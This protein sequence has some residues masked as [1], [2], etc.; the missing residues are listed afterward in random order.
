M[1]FRLP[2]RALFVVVSVPFALLA[3]ARVALA[4]A[5][6]PV[7]GGFTLA[8]L[9]DTQIYTWK[10]PETYP[11]QTRWI[12]DNARLY[13]TAYVLH[14]GDITQHNTNHQWQIA[15]DAHALLDRKG[16]PC[17]ITTG[18]HDLGTEGKG[19]TRETPFAK[20]FPVEWFRKQPTFGG[21]YDKE[22]HRTDNNYHLFEAGGRKWLILCLEFGPRDDVLRWGNEVVAKH[23]DRSAIL[24]THA[25][26]RPDNFRFNRNAFIK[27]KDFEVNLGMDRYGLAKGEGGFNDGED[28]W[29]KLVSQHASFV[30]VVS[31]HVC[32]TGRL[33]STGKHGNT[34]HQMVVDYQNQK[35][36]GEGYLRLLQFH[37]DGKKV[38]VADY[39]PLLDKVSSAKNT[40]YEFT[41]APPPAATDKP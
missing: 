20:Y 40:S 36:G 25:Y 23:P 21:F 30:L 27:V 35:D 32:I 33:E 14:V 15:S 19:S 16:I 6:A 7:P 22:P 38:S 12:A 8:V 5:P 26:L 3:L 31:G 18:N 29:K 17:A 2:R 24:V 39:S 9:P 4:D 1:S 11:A 10:H 28:V 41:I 37:P 13:N 34:V